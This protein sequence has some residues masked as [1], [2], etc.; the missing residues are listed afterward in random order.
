[1]SLIPLPA[2]PTSPTIEMTV[3]DQAQTPDFLV[4]Q[5]RFMAATDGVP[6]DISFPLSWS[7]RSPQRFKSGSRVSMWYPHESLSY[8]A[9]VLKSEFPAPIRPFVYDTRLDRGRPSTCVTDIMY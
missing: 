3:Y 9:T 4:L 7:Y 1:V 8:H 6:L 2:T 5:S